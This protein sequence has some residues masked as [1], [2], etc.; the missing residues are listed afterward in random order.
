MVFV[1]VLLTAVVF[2]AGGILL[3]KEDRAMKEAAKSKKSPIFLSPEKSL[4]P[5]NMDDKK[6]YHLSHSW[7]AKSEDENVLVGFDNFISFSSMLKK[8][9]TNSQYF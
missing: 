3:R 8:L 7:M 4:L 5:V 1:F 6:Y 2:I 9:V